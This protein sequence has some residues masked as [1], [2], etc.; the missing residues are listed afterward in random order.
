MNHTYLKT[1]VNG[2]PLHTIKTSPRNVILKALDGNVASGSEY[3]INGGFFYQKGL[4]SI[5]VNNDIPCRGKKEAYGSGWFNEKYTRGTLVWDN[6]ASKYSIQHVRDVSEI[7]VRDRSA[8]WAQG[9]ISMNLKDNAIWK[10]EAV[11]QNMPN[12]TGKV[13]RTALVYNSGMNLYLI[14]TEYPCTAEAFR[15]AIK[16]LANGTIVDGVFLD[17]SGSSQMKCKQ[18]AINGDGRIVRQMVALT[19]K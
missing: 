15:A 18:V 19:N 1:I 16:K 14:V 9:G 7:K 12:M 8:Y 13:G 5:A 11:K 3:G 4:V 2:I 10:S 17:G 6:A